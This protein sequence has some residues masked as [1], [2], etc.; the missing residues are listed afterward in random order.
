MS[1]NKANILLSMPYFYKD[2]GMSELS[3][4]INENTRVVICAFAFEDLSVY[5]EET[6]NRRYSK[7]GQEYRFDIYGFLKFGIKE[8]NIKWINY[9]T[10]NHDTA[11]EKI[12]SSDLVFFT[13]GLPDRMY[14]RLVEFDLVDALENFSGILMGYSAGA[15]VQIGDYHITPDSD[16]PEYMYAKG[17]KCVTDF[18]VEVH[19][20]DEPQQ[21]EGTQRAIRERGLPVYQMTNDGGLILAGGEVTML[22]ECK[23]IEPPK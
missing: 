12:H 4:Y 11:L 14:E 1:K 20:N 17:L 2:W 10:D 5:N 7:H 22:G 16:Y 18:D 6:W 13:G 15:M 8:E 23:L 9:Y 21:N 3:K 19:Y